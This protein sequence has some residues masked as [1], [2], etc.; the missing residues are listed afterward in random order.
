MANSTA[1]AIVS[2][3]M[4]FLPYIGLR[5]LVPL[6]VYFPLSMSFALIN[7]A[8]KLP[9]GTKYVLV[10]CYRR[11]NIHLSV[12]RFGEGAGFILS[13]FYIYLGM[14]ALGLSLEA[15]I[16]L[17]TPRFIPFFLFILVRV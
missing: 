7:V 8:F 6:M 1:R 4:D 5:I 12:R 14:A 2:P 9:L 11:A 10:Y 16:T 13:F 3:H 15:M 17:L